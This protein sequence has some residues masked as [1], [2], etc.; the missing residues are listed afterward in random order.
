M[1]IQ[2][3]KKLSEAFGPSGTEDESR[4]ILRDELEQYADE[5]MVDKLGNIFFTHKGNQ[6][7]PKIML[8]AHTDEVAVL[9]TYIEDSGVL[10][11]YPW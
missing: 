10:R 1:N 6:K 7:S 4:S 2:L 3:L 9:I 8:A 11:F 5:V